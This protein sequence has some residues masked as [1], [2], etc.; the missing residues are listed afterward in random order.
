MDNVSPE[1]NAVQMRTAAQGSEDAAEQLTAATTA[2]NATLRTTCV[3]TMLDGGHALNAL[4][5][6]AGATVNCRVLPEM[7][8]EEVLTTLKRVVADDQV[9]ITGTRE[10]DAGPASPLRPDLFKAASRITD[11]MW[12]GLPAI[13]IMVMGATDG[14]A[15]RTAGIPTY[16][17]QGIF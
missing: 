3:A 10:V 15:L 2:L 13:P 6:T 14:L 12:P 7:K 9:S 4:P 17:V 5:Q 1:P 16:V 11:T 8:P